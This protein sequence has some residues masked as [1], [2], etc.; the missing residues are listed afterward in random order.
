[1]GNST[2]ENNPFAIVSKQN[3]TF[4]LFFPV[5]SSF[6]LNCSQEVITMEHTTSPDGTVIGFRRSGAGQPLVLVHG[7][8]ADHMRWS[9]ILPH[10][11]Q[12]FTVYAMDRRGRGSSSDSPDYDFKREAEDVAAVVEAACEQV[13]EPVNL[14][15]HSYGALCS[16]EAALLSDKVKRLILYEPPFPVI[17]SLF[18]Q[19]FRSDT[20]TG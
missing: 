1:M 9:P 14:L 15:G 16:L 4:V 2:D 17:A 13:G 11:E 3:S 20:S 8:T 10:F 6:F 5:A 12:H 19:A 18:R 7:A